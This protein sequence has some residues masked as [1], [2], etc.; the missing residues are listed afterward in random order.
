MKILLQNT[1]R[2]DDSARTHSSIV[3]ICICTRVAAGFAA[4]FA[5]QLRPWYLAT[6]LEDSAATTNCN[7]AS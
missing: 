7:Y 2:G 1:A 3:S 5:D 4:G 6:L